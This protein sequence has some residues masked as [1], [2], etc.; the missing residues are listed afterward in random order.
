[1]LVHSHCT[2]GGGTTR[3]LD[4]RQGAAQFQYAGQYSDSESG[5]QYDR[6]RYYDPAVGGFISRDP[7][8]AATRQ[9]YGYEA[10]SPINGSDPGGLGL[11]DAGNALLGGAHDVAQNVPAALAY[12]AL[13]TAVNEHDKLV[14]GDPLQ[15][16][17]AVVDILALAFPLA[18]GLAG[19]VAII[20]A[21]SAAVGAESAAAEAGGDTITLYHGSIDNF[22]TIMEQGL[23][24]ARAP[25]WVTTERAAAENAIGPGR[26]LSTGQGSDSGVVTS[27][28]PRS[29]FEAIKSAGGISERRAWPGFGGGGPFSEY[30]LRSDDAIRLFNA[31][32]RG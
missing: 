27:V 23:D 25:T 7:A 14:S 32:I 8:A 24:P 13:G 19:K 3:E 9:P 15:V 10:D 22:S 17:S 1:M 29:S 18:I 30:V 21:E 20:G 16:T 12:I 6:A 28:V 26:V 31:G 2:W 11:L 5:L 4:Q